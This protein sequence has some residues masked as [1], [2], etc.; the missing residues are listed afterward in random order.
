MTANIDISQSQAEL[1]YI[2]SV[3]DMSSDPRM[4]S[5]T[6]DSAN[7]SCMAL[8][9]PQ[10]NTKDAHASAASVSQI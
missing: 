1:V 7:D 9:Q 2:L 5:G 8:D 3:H 4:L 10:A 6:Q